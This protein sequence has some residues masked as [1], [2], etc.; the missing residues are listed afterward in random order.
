MGR[1]K[2]REVRHKGEESDMSLCLR[3]RFSI[4][5]PDGFLRNFVQKNA[6]KFNLEGTAQFLEGSIVLVVVCG[7]RDNVDLFVDAIHEKSDKYKIEGI[8]LEPF[9]KNR[10]YRRAFRCM[11]CAPR[12]S[13]SY[14]KDLPA[15]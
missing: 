6:K 10:D 14:G 4:G 11:A 8:E 3:I 15:F 13:L 7:A 12:R 9:L 2:K 1:K 5:S